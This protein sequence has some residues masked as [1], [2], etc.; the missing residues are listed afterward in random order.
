[1]LV[2]RRRLTRASLAAGLAALAAFCS[3]NGVTPAA[4][5]HAMPFDRTTA[6]SSAT[7]AVSRSGSRA[8]LE[9][10]S[11]TLGETIDGQALTGFSASNKT[12]QDL[13]NGRDRNQQPSGFD[14]D[15]ATGDVGNAYEFSQCT[16]W[17]YV[18]RHELN[19]PVGSHMGNGA[20]WADSARRL[21]YWVDNTPRVGDVMVF[22][23]GQNGNSPVYGHVAVVEAVNDDGSID[24][25]ECGSAF[26]GVPFTRRYDAADAAAHEFIHY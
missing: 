6:V 25:S 5:G 10:G 12:V 13:L 15:H 11:W 22:S 7:L 17:V 1:M 8:D 24:T 19:L 16:W 21:G 26:N 23:Y 9:T 14:P 2:L 3:L 20:Q 4:F 18:R